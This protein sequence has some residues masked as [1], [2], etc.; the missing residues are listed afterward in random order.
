MA[1]MSLFRAAMG[2]D[3]IFDGQPG[4]AIGRSRPPAVEMKPS[5]TT[6]FRRAAAARMTPAMPPISKPPTLASTSRPSRG[7]GRLSAKAASTA[8]IFRANCPSSM[9]VPRPVTAATGSP[10]DRGDHGGRGRRVG[11]AHVAGAEHVG[12]IG[13]RLDHLDARLDRPATAWARVM[14]GPLGDVGRA[15]GDFLRDD[16]S[17]GDQRAQ[18]GGHAHVD[19]HHAGAGQPAQGVDPRHAAAKP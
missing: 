9:P 8:A 12:R 18:V 7:S 10:R 4:G 5:T 6:G 11:D 3:D 14:A 17:R 1:A 19:D 13:Q 15:G 2:G 16:L